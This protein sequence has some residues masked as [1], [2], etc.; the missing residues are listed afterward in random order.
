MHNSSDGNRGASP[1]DN[2]QAMRRRAR[3]GSLAGKS[4]AEDSSRGGKTTAQSV[5]SKTVNIS[6]RVAAG[7]AIRTNSTGHDP[8]AGGYSPPKAN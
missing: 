5:S 3:S 1:K 4:Y 7:A 6:N 2:H 8:Y